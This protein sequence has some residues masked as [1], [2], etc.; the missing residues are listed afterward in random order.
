MNLPQRTLSLALEIQRISAPAFSKAER[1]GEVR[2]Q[3]E[4][5]KIIPLKHGL[6]Q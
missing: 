5:I 2:T 4:Y 3:T 6:T 1:N